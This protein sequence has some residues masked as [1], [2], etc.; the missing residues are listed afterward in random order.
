MKKISLHPSGLNNQQECYSENAI[1]L[2]TLTK[3]LKGFIITEKQFINEI[4][5][6][7][8]K[9]RKLHELINFVNLVNNLIF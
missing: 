5:Y 1:H 4:I 2:V 9:I 6:N 8:R 7:K 3:Y